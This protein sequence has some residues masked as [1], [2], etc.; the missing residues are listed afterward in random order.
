MQELE[1]IGTTTDC[2]VVAIIR[3][4]RLLIGLRHYTPTNPV[5]TIPGGRC[6][7]GDTLEATLLR[8]VVEEVGMNNVSIDK[9]LGA[10]PGAKE[11]DTVYVFVGSTDEDPVLMEPEKFSE[12]TWEKLKDIPENFI[13]PAAL[14]LIKNH[15]YGRPAPIPHG[16][17]ETH[18]GY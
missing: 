15:V 10:V 11:G 18:A 9:F 14:E 6:D 16:D 13:N 17:E 2:P 7:D 4:G 12:W 1:K 3:N 8:E 5:W